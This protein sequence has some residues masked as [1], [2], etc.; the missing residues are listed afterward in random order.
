MHVF[1]EEM[2]VHKMGS[3]YSVHS[4]S[5][6]LEVRLSTLRLVREKA[7][8]PSKRMME[9]KLRKPRRAT[10]MANRHLA[11]AMCICAKNF[12]AFSPLLLVRIS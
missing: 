10:I 8:H 5:K 12:N 11:L 1:P 4:A 2:R 3:K 7:E 9:T 6:E